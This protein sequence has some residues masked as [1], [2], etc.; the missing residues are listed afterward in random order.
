MNACQFIENNFNYIDLELPVIACIFEIE[1]IKLKQ[2]S[3]HEVLLLNFFKNNPYHKCNFEE[4]LFLNKVDA[5]NKEILKEVLQN[6]LSIKTL[7]NNSSYYN[8]LQEMSVGLSPL[9]EKLFEQGYVLTN[10]IVTEKYTLYYDIATGAFLTENETILPR[11][12]S[13]FYQKNYHFLREY[14][15]D[16]NS[17]LLE[18][19]FGSLPVPLPLTEKYSAFEQENAITSQIK[20]GFYYAKEKLSR[21]KLTSRL[22]KN[23]LSLAGSSNKLSYHIDKSFEKTFKPYSEAF[24]NAALGKQNNQHS[25]TF[26]FNA[27]SFKYVSWTT[28]E[29]QNLLSDNNYLIFIPDG[30]KAFVPCTDENKI[31]RISKQLFAPKTEFEF[32]IYA[33]DY[34]YCITQSFYHSKEFK[35]YQGNRISKEKFFQPFNFY[36]ESSEVDT[37][38]TELLPILEKT[39]SL[40]LFI[41][42]VNQ[43]KKIALQ[44]LLRANRFFK[45]NPEWKSFFKRYMQDVI[46]RDIL[47]NG[48]NNLKNLLVLQ[49]VAEIPKENILEIVQKADYRV[50][51]PLEY[52]LSLLERKCLWYDELYLHNFARENVKKDI[53]A[54]AQFI[55]NKE[56]I[57]A[58]TYNILSDDFKQII[59]NAAS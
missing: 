8:D 2:I 39:N 22:I 15:Q 49:R 45:N 30:I 38:F 9:G 36:L 43:M 48:Y 13:F 35:D 12:K 16:D 11:A 23:G 7:F 33:L 19:N 10:S 18:K 55:N 40:S 6:L 27:D 44:K 56:E 17:F 50:S 25:D 54:L 28:E 37:L 53:L 34:M 26:N 31:V 29:L 42:A 51:L 32:F 21:K 5:E 14:L 57:S 47:Q 20:D 3:Y 46:F 4:L 41:T 52:S 58:N 59:N 24:I 1:K